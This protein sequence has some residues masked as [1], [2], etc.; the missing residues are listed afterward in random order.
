MECKWID[1][2]PLRKFE[3][4]GRLDMKW[5]KQYCKSD[6]KNCRRYQMEE[7]GIQHPDAMLPDG[8]IDRDLE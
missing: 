5:R 8:K 3:K 1:I 7:E 2:C 6:F 4:Q